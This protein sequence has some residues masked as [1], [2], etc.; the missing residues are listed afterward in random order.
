MKSRFHSLTSL[1]QK[2][3]SDL[4]DLLSKFENVVTWTTPRNLRI[5][6]LRFTKN[7]VPKNTAFVFKFPTEKVRHFHTV[8][9]EF[10]INIFFFDKKGKIVSIHL[11][12]KPG[13][14]EI[15]SKGKSMYVVEFPS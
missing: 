7:N 14:S 1:I 10:N 9:M 3:E 6:M 15:S 12:V 8:G 4:D 13:T 11:D 2:T 5:G